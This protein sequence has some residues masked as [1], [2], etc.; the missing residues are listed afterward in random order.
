LTISSGQCLLE[1]LRQ[2]MDSKPVDVSINTAKN[3]A[4]ASQ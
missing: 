3:L 1:A 4:E 2:L